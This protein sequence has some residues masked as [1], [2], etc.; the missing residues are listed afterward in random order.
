MTP[1]R[2]IVIALAAVLVACGA[3]CVKYTEP[4]AAV[5][6]EL[7]PA[8]RNFEANWLAAQDVLRSYRFTIDRR[9]K[10]AGVITTKP[11]TGMQ[12]FEFWRRDAVTPE[13]VLAGSIQTIHRTATV[14]IVASDPAGEKHEPVVHVAVTKPYDTAAGIRS[15]SEAYSMFLLPGEREDPARALLGAGAEPTEPALAKPAGSDVKLARRLREEITV[16]AARR[17]A[18][19]R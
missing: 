8:E 15:T 19:G 10:R 11:L 16:A 5:T 1:S 9:D 7:T 14:R 4:V 18:G 2:T 13:A 17:L 6:A 3:G 12:Y